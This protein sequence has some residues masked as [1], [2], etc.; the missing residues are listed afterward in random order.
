MDMIDEILETYH[1]QEIA[2]K[3][4][5]ARWYNSKVIPQ[6]MK[7]GYLFLKQVVAL[8]RIGKLLSN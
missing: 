1:I 2:A 5:V 4:R 7:E 6:E 3:Q 8:T